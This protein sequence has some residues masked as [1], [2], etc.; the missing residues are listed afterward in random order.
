MDIPLP[1]FIL[2]LF[3]V[4]GLL[5]YKEKWGKNKEDVGLAILELRRMGGTNS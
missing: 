5:G 1:I 2:L 3:L 4:G